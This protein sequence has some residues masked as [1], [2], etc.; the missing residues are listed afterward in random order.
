MLEQYFWYLAR[1][2]H[3]IPDHIRWVHFLCDRGIFNTPT[4]LGMFNFWLTLYNAICLSYTPLSASH[5]PSEMRKPIAYGPIGPKT[6]KATEFTQ[7]IGFWTRVT[8]STVPSKFLQKR[9][10]T[11]IRQLWANGAGCSLIHA[12]VSK[13][14]IE[15]QYMHEQ[16]QVARN[17][18]TKVRSS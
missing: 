4:P 6:I 10:L 1:R 18:G 7:F 11:Q 15:S 17:E 12:C 3:S 9:V 16:P 14:R 2:A 8:L 5:L 13:Y